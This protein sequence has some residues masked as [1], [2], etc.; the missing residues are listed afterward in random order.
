MDRL[1]FRLQEHKLDITIS[2][3]VKLQSELVFAQPGAGSHSRSGYDSYHS[4][5]QFNTDHRDVLQV[6]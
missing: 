4:H 3:P 2:A 6:F 5:T 1:Q